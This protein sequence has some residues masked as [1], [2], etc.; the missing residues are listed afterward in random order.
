MSKRPTDHLEP[1]AKKRGNERQLTKDDPS[2]D[3]EVISDSP[4]C[5]AARQVHKLSGI[6]CQD[7]EQPGEF[8]KASEEVMKKRKIVRPKRA[9]ATLPGSSAGAGGANP[10]AGISFAAPPQTDAFASVAK[11]VPITV[12][13]V[14]KKLQ[15]E[16]VPDV[17]LYH[18]GRCQ[19]QVPL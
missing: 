8:M 1:A 4:A 18:A 11:Q 13:S 14:N 16:L 12:W 7:Q 6:A 10:F 15:L 3:E 9:A 2:D 19:S 5:C 17:S